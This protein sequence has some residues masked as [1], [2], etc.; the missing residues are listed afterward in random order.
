MVS[1]NSHCV[2]F[3]DS[4]LSVFYILLFIFIFI[5][6]YF[7]FSIFRTARVRTDWSHCYISYN[8][9]A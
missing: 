9:M 1:V 4:G 7:L 5:L 2:K 3:A 8:L 6:F